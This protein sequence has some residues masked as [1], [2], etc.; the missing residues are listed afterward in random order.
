MSI[1]IDVRAVRTAWVRVPAAI[2]A[3]AVLGVLPMAA[4]AAAPPRAI[5]HSAG[6]SGPAAAPG[7]IVVGFRSGV[8]GGQRVAARSA[9]DVHAKRNLLARGVQLVTVDSGQSVQEAIAVLEKRSDVR[10]AE[11]NWIYHAAS[12][13][14][15][16]PR[17]G[18]LWGL[19]NT[20]QS[21]GTADA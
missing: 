2:V 10:Y 13:T 14:P 16:D 1:A 21:G 17:F 6:P 5:L 4:G 18:D 8:D 20:T 11:P 12:T 3:G 7:E 9:A 15:D 19:N